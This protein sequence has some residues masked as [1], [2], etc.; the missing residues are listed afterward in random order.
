MRQIESV[1]VIGMG[2][3]GLPLAA[4]F[5]KAGVRVVGVDIDSAKCERLNAGESYI[6]RVSSDAL[7]TLVDEGR[8]T[9]T[10]DHAKLADVDAICICVPTPIDEARAPDLTAVKDTARRVGAHLKKGQLVVLEST[11]YPG[12]TDEVVKPI[13]EETSGLSAEADFLIAFSPEREDPGNKNFNVTN[14]PKVVGGYTPQATES[15]TALYGMVAPSVVPVASA[16]VAEATKMLENTYRAVNIALVNELKVIFQ[17]L[18]INIWD[19]IEA[20]KTKP[21]GFHAFTPGPGMG[22]HCIPVDPFYLS[23]KART[24]GE[25]ARFIELAGQVNV[26]MPRYVVERLARSL[27][28]LGKPLSRSSVFLLG[29]AYKPDIDDDR[30][31]PFYEIADILKDRGATVS[32]HDPH[33]PRIRPTRHHKLVLESSP[34]TAEILA[35]A[36]AVVVV[37]NHSTFDPA[38]IAKHSQ[39]VVDTRNLM[40]GITEG[41]EKIVIA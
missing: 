22:G 2:Y 35:A 41:R 13:L 26:E 33:I 16:R 19:V 15:A 36:D 34:L 32:Y 4:G 1:G 21:F 5:A 24:L 31:S 7:K 37:T 12:T 29:A 40:A 8:F 10:T 27:D 6:E 3:V 28:G 30:E 38:F 11:T 18:D 14:I 9:A 39:L 25:E 20:A 17:R 23:F